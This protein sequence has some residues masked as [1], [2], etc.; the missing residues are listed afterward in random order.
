MLT[1][2]LSS[3]FGSQLVAGG[4]GAKNCATEAPHE[5]EVRVREGFGARIRLDRGKY[6]GEEV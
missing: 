6:E 2:L 3:L 4:G 1:N 5:E